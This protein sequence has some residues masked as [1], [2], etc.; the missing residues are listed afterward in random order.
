MSRFA[1]IYE[2]PEYE[3][4][5]ESDEGDWVEV[6]IQPVVKIQQEDEEIYSPYYGA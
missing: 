5:L 3:D 1:V 2:D 4:Y 6:E